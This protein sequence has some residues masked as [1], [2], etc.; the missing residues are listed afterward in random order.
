MNP[1]IWLY[2][3]SISLAT[4]VELLQAG[5]N[6]NPNN[7]MTS[8]LQQWHTF[9]IRKLYEWKLINQAVIPRGRAEADLSL[10]GVRKLPGA[11]A[12]IY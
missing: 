11:E 7:D 4:G 10:E 6:A 5:L 8:H 9:L 3:P 1:Q 12:C 2:Y